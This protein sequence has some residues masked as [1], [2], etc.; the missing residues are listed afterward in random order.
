MSNRA[1][2]KPETSLGKRPLTAELAL[3]VDFVADPALALLRSS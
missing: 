2:N 1:S 3:A